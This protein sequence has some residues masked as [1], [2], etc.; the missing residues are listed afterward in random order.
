MRKTYY[1]LA[2]LL[3]IFFS[4]CREDKRDTLIGAWEQISH[5]EPDTIRV[6]WQFY[7]GDALQ[8]YVLDQNN[9][10]VGDTINYA[11]G[12]ESST[13]SIFKGINDSIVLPIGKDPV[14]DYWIDVLKKDEFKATKR[15]DGNGYNVYVRI[16]LIKR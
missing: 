15:K 5:S 6:F 9:E 7:A 2:V 16:E 3:V 8:L 10:L 14:G 12:L 13:L 1:I 4:G 11:Y